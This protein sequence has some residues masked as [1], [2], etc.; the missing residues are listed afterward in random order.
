MAA[1]AAMK[2]GSMTPE[3]RKLAEVNRAVAVK[4]GGGTPANKTLG[5]PSGL[6]EA[7]EIREREIPDSILH[8][9]AQAMAQRAGVTPKVDPGHIQ[10]LMEG[11]AGSYMKNPTP[12]KAQPKNDPLAA[13][14]Q[15]MESIE[16]K[17]AAPVAPR[18]ESPKDLLN[19]IAVNLRKGG[20]LKEEIMKIVLDEAMTENRLVPLMEKHFKRMLTQFLQER[21]KG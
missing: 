11:R 9:N 10:A 18:Q 6:N 19:E 14:N 2:A 20:V 12:A 16:R 21:K 5:D 13:A 3:A 15:L 1:L 4:A 7:T 17:Q 8:V